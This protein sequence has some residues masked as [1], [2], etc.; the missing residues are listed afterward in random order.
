LLYILLS[1]TF[2][3][4]LFFLSA[5]STVDSL[6]SSFVC[7]TNEAIPP[8]Y[9]GGPY[10]S[11]AS[12]DFSVSIQSI[13][14][15]PRSASQQ[16]VFGND[17]SAFNNVESHQHGGKLHNNRPLSVPNTGNH[18]KSYLYRSLESTHFLKE[19]DELNEQ[20]HQVQTS[21]N[22]SLTENR[23]S[24]ADDD[25]N[26]NSDFE[27]PLVAQASEVISE[28]ID[29]INFINNINENPKSSI[30]HSNDSLSVAMLDKI[31]YSRKTNDCT[32]LNMIQ[33]QLEKCCEMI[34]QQQQQIQQT[35]SHFEDISPLNGARKNSESTMGINFLSSESTVSSLANLTGI[36]SPPRATSPTQ[37]VKDLLEQINKLKQ[38][39]IAEDES[40]MDT[41]IVQNISFDYELGS[42]TSNKSVLKRPTTFSSKR[43]NLHLKNRSFYLPI[44]CGTGNEIGTKVK[45]PISRPTPVFAGGKSLSFKRKNIW[46][47]K[48]APTTPYEGNNLPEYLTSDRSPLLNENDED[49]IVDNDC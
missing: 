4:N 31:S 5:T 22:S 25:L 2:D 21:S 16:H 24:D 10:S 38:S 27:S 45:S 48:S 28:E 26:E 46:I 47:S 35:S 23:H 34:N 43:K 29:M 49:A 33:A 14:A 12:P 32:K 41:R 9:P 6:S 7:T 13:S 20:R 3:R 44:D 1:K 42:S 18:S 37:E 19:G 15:V 11:A 36:N 17:T 40:K 39:N 8:P 30:Y